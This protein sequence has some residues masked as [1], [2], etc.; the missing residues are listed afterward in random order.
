M[1]SVTDHESWLA[2]TAEDA[3]LDFKE[4]FDAGNN[5]DWLEIV[6]EVVA[7]AN[8]GGGCIIIGLRDDGLPSG[9]DVSSVIA[10]DPAVLTDKIYK[11]TGAQFH[12]FGIRGAVKDTAA[13]CLI[14]VY[15]CRVPLVFTKVGTYE[16]VPGKQKNAF[17]QG[18]IYFRHGAKSEPATMD[19]LRQC[20]EREVDRLRSSWL[21]GIAKVVEA[22]VGSQ[23]VVI[24][25]DAPPTTS[26]AASSVRLTND[27]AAPT[28]RALPIDE[29]HPYR[30]KEVVLEVNKALAGAHKIT[31]HDILCV[32]RIHR[33]EDD[34]NLCFTQKYASPRYS[35]KFVDWVIE[36]YRSAPDFFAAMRHQYDARG[37]APNTTKQPT[38]DPRG[39]GG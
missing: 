10:M 37:K 17:S 19:D 18:A 6:K 29:T 25:A 12:E 9:V 32:R 28:W 2:R 16:T 35:Q 14:R 39:S 5:G 20:I 8:S 34:P 23:I 31:T 1:Q 11:Y 38:G 33:V 7:M 3:D 4:S 36:K 22:P 27:L 24:P 21:D 30:Q 15:G 13:V 26:A